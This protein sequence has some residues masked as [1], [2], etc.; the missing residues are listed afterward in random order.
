[1][2]EILLF[3]VFLTALFLC[4]GCSFGQSPQSA[5]V[6]VTRP[7]PES[8]DGFGGARG[9]DYS[10]T[11]TYRGSRPPFPVG[12]RVDREKT[13]THRAYSDREERQD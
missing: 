13:E 12:L 7:R 1:M 2:L 3:G 6:K 9:H 11:P 8:V 4:A 10:Y 5:E